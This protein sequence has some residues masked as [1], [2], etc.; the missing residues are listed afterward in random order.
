MQLIFFLDK[1]RTVVDALA[2]CDVIVV[3]QNE[4]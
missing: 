1:A 4:M 3:I 2:I